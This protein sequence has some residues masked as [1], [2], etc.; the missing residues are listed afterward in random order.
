MVDLALECIRYRARHDLSQA[1]MGK[2][3]KLH[4]TVI[5]DVENGHEYS[6]LTQEKIMCV[7]EKE[8]IGNE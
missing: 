3:C 6:K 5:C 7:I 8:E 2:L 1:Q 4:R